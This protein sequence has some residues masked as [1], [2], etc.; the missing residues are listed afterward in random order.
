[1]AFLK[2]ILFFFVYGISRIVVSTFL[3]N[4][5]SALTRIKI[6]FI[7]QNSVICGTT[8]KWNNSFFFQRKN[9]SICMQLFKTNVG[10][11]QNQEVTVTL[12]L[13]LIDKS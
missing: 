8:G 2:K 12:S 10:V 13:S 4:E 11:S 3:S 7:F 5:E 9:F 6:T 1:M